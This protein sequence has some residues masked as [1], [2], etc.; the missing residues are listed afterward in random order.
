MPVISKI[1]RT[2]TGN[3]M[4]GG[5]AKT[6]NHPSPTFSVRQS[7]SVRHFLKINHS[8]K[9]MS[10]YLELTIMYLRTGINEKICSDKFFL[11]ARTT[12]LHMWNAMFVTRAVIT[13]IAWQGRFVTV[14]YMY[15]LLHIKVNWNDLLNFFGLIDNRE[16]ETLAQS[17][18]NDMGPFTRPL[19]KTIFVFIQETTENFCF[20]P[21]SLFR[22]WNT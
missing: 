11:V 6:T 9:P 18:E 1:F 14:G 3:T 10:F 8:T 2:R 22:G 4:R 16:E 20:R 5:N 7:G 21:L 13:F 19:F 12:N 15:L 17:L